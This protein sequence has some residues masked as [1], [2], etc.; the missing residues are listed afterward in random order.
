MHAEY[1]PLDNP[2]KRVGLHYS[3]FRSPLGT[4]ILE[5]TLFP[6]SKKFS[7]RLNPLS[8]ASTLEE[9]RKVDPYRLT[10]FCIFIVCIIY[11]LYLF[12]NSNALRRLL[13]IK[14]HPR[15]IKDTKSSLDITYLV[16]GNEC[17]HIPDAPTFKYLGAFLGFSYSHIEHMSTDD[18]N[19]KYKIGK[20]LPSI[21]LY[22]IKAD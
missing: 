5:N 4:P 11:W 13:N 8:R 15:L 10:V 6:A 17:H 22:V 14:R 2:E 19:R 20:Q 1:H 9:A 12:I 16:E 21:L 18:I 7:R 3:L